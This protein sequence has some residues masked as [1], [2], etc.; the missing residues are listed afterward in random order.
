M[1][2]RHVDER[3]R[4][5]SRAGRGSDGDQAERGRVRRADAGVDGRHRPRTDE[6]VDDGLAPSS[7]TFSHAY[8]YRELPAVN[9]VVHTHSTYATAW[10]ARRR[11]D[12]VRAHR[13]G[14]RVRRRDPDR[15][16]RP[17]RRRRHRPRGRVDA[18]TAIAR[19]PC[20]CATT[21]CSP[22]APTPQAR[23]QGGRDVRGRRPHRAPRAAAR[24]TRRS[25]IR[26]T[27][28]ACT[29]ATRAP[30]GRSEA[31]RDRMSSYDDRQIW[32]LTGSQ[33]L[34]GDETLRQVADQSGAI[35]APAQRRR[36]DPADGRAPAGAQGADGDPSSDARRQLRS[37]RASA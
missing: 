26:P 17:D 2:A 32:F 13:D 9:G 1:G 37:A 36:D 19:R 22:S 18:A 24:R 3:Q 16:L 5:R 15:P 10:A 35:V 4:Q 31:S 34:Y 21:A 23:G 20:C 27:S 12:P 7:D 11:G 6:P 30:T 33:T 14:R 28:T 25:S 8:I 29:S